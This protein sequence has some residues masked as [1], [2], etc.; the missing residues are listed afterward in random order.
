M[1]KYKIIVVIGT[2]AVGGAERVLSILSEPLADH[3]S[4]VKFVLWVNNEVSY[5]IDSRVKIVSL[6]DK[7]HTENRIKLI[8]YFREFVKEENPDLILS[9]LTPFNML[10]L[11]AMRGIH[12][13]VIVAE[14]A[15]PKWIKGGKPMMWLRDHLYRKAKGILTQ[16]EYAK[17]CY[18]DCLKAKTTVIYNPVTMDENQ[19]GSALR[20][21]KE[22]VFVTAGRLEPV[23]NQLMMINAFGRFHKTHTDYRLVIFGE[24]PMRNDLMSQ[25]ISLGL[26]GSVLLSGNSKSLWQEMAKAECFL[27]TSTN[28]GMSNAMIEAM[29]L[30]LPVISTKVAGATDLIQNGEN[31]FLIDVNDTN[32]LILKMNFLADNPGLRDKVGQ[33]AQEIYSQLRK[34]IVCQEWVNYLL[35]QIE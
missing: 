16:T 30:G 6:V 20:C 19:V 8:S 26:Q 29:C 7:Y 28:E 24:G 34:E 22:K 15:D 4:D 17:S 35:R 14:R 9:F 33:K 32:A 31:G 3:F 18:R 27:L 1:H 2:L 23:K 5:N 11:V 13:P 21:K 25:I 12:I 10:T